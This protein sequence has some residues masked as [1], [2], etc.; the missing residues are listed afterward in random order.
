MRHAPAHIL[1]QRTVAKVK[2]KQSL[3]QH[4]LDNVDLPEESLPRQTV[5]ELLGDGRVLIEQHRGVLEYGPERIGVR[6]SF[7]SVCVTGSNLRLGLM[8]CQKLVILGKIRGI[9]LVR[10]KC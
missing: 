7:G 3:M 6:V 8:T 2:K 9:E 5:V 10:G 4:L 1:G